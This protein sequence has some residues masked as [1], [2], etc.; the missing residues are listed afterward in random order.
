MLVKLMRNIEL[1]CAFSS[2]GFLLGKIHVLP[3]VWCRF[4][5]TAAVL[6]FSDHIFDGIQF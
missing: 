1:E 6:N 4:I 3:V 2:T 5:D